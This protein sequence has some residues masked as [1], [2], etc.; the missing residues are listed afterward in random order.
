MVPEINSKH[1]GDKE[2]K[3]CIM[4]VP[5]S[6]PNVQHNWMGFRQPEAQRI[7]AICCGPSKANS[8]PVGSR[9]VSP[10]E[11]GGYALFAGCCMAYQPQLFK[12]THRNVNMLD[13]GSGLPID[14]SIDL[15][16]GYLG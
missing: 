8:C 12:T 16:T 13:A 2:Y 10:C 9:T 5:T 3:V 6:T 15:M 7:K 11:H 4:Y 14:Y 1:K